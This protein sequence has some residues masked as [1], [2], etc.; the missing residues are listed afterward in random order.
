MTDAPKGANPVRADDIETLRARMAESRWSAA[1]IAKVD[2]PQLVEIEARLAEAQAALEAASAA[3][4]RLFQPVLDDKGRTVSL[5]SAIERGHAI[6]Q[7]SRG[8]AVAL[9]KGHAQAL[10]A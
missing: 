3:A 1:D 4:A 7:A 10:K 6:V 5:A 9:A 8:V 2:G